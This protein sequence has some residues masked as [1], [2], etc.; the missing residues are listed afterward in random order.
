MNRIITALGLLLSVSTVAQQEVIGAPGYRPQTVQATSMKMGDTISLPFID[1]FSTVSNVPSQKR[2][3]DAKVHINNT[4]PIAQRSRGVATFDGLDEGGKAYALNRP[5]LDSVTDVLTSKY[6]NLANVNS[7]FLAFSYQQGG[8]GESPESGDSLFVDFWNVDSSIWERVWSV[9]GGGVQNGWSWASVSANDPK[10]LKKGFRFRIGIYGAP[11]GGYDV[12]NLDYLSMES[13]RTAAD[14][15]ISDPAITLPHPKLIEDFTAVPWFHMGSVT[16]ASQLEFD[17]RRNGPVPSGGWSLNLGKYRVFQDGNLVDEDLT[18]PVVTNL[19]HNVDLNFTVNYD[20]SGF[21]TPTAVTELSMTTWFDGE[22]VGIRKND[23]ITYRQTF[24]NDYAFDDG[25]AERVYGLTDA[26]SYLLYRFQPLVSDTLKG[27]KIFFGQADDD[28]TQTPFKIVVYS[29]QNGAPGNIIYE[30]DSAY[31]PYFVGGNNQFGYYPL[32]TTGLW[33]NGTV[34]IGLKQLSAT[35]LT[36]GLDRNVEGG[37]TTIVYGD[38]LNWY[39]SQEVGALM[40]RPYFKYHP[41]DISV[42]DYETS[43]A[44]V[45]PNPAEEWVRI[46]GLTG[47]STTQII[48]LSGNIVLQQEDVTSETTLDISSLTTGFYIIRWSNQIASGVEKILIQ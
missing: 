17:Y 37:A 46:D 15:I 40:L 2:W 3:V 45:Y 25:S 16:Y 23:S 34:F 32:D 44:V 35:P 14:T 6:I 28:I 22:A 7:P 27:F 8:W 21:Q 18:V 29:F 24:D 5:N 10:W 12:W 41:D 11:H 26:D 1:D 30:S 39:P 47:P 38:G 31:A 33:I 36:V 48:D 42:A 20:P 9:D 4:F 13:G 19:D 43:S